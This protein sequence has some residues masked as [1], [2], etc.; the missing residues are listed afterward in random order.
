MRQFPLKNVNQATLGFKENMYFFH[1]NLKINILLQT[2]F[3]FGILIFT[4]KKEFS[5]TLWAL[6]MLSLC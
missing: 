3:I 4:K 2:I 6:S 1:A 5:T